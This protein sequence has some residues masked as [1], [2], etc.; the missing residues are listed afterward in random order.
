MKY[1]TYLHCPVSLLVRGQLPCWWLCPMQSEQFRDLLYHGFI[2]TFIWHLNK[3]RKKSPEQFPHLWVPSICVHCPAIMFWHCWQHKAH[4][5]QKT[6][7]SIKKYPVMPTNGNIL[8]CK[9]ILCNNFQ[10]F[11]KTDCDAWE[12]ITCEAVMIVRT[13]TSTYKMPAYS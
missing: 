1:E 8:L 7:I 9:I 4:S 11:Q 5:H 2:T 3:N 13:Y 12:F 10:E 6:S